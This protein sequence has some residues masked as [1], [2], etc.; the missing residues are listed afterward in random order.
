MR[1]PRTT[2]RPD[3]DKVARGLYP[4]T[5]GERA[6]FLAILSALLT[7]PHITRT[8]TGWTCA[9]G[10]V[11]GNNFQRWTAAVRFAHTWHASM[12]RYLLTR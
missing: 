3:V 7:K 2:Y 5:A 9:I 12:Y 6:H 8:A 4:F 10:N 1:G 11:H